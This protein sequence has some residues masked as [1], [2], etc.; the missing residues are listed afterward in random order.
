MEDVA[1]N[2]PLVGEM[3]TTIVADNKGLAITAIAP[4]VSNFQGVSF[5]VTFNDDGSISQADASLT[6]SEAAA[7]P[8][9]LTIPP[10]LF[11]DL[12]LNPAEVVDFRVGFSVF[13]D[14][15]LFQ[16]RSS[17][18]QIESEGDRM[19]AIGSSVLSAQVSGSGLE[20]TV[21]NLETPVEV[22]L[23][24][25]PVCGNNFLGTNNN[26]YNIDAWSTFCALCI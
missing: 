2:L 23:S 14:D 21:D 25:K 7:A 10:S 6:Q 18:E 9:S 1:D 22:E 17:G 26:Y 13:R 16:P 15:S 4:E 3:P 20:I 19:S 24:M 5:E 8:T 11:M 12:G